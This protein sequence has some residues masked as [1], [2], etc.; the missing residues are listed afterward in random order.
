MPCRVIAPFVYDQAIAYLM[1]RWK[2]DKQR[3]LASIAAKLSLF[4]AY[5]CEIDQLILPMPLHWRRQLERGF[6]QS[7]DLL[8]AMAKH[9][10]S[11]A[12]QR[13]QTRDVP[14]LTRCRATPK[15]SLAT[16]RERQRNLAGAFRV[17]GD[18][19]G[20]PVLVIDD[21]CTTGATAAAVTHA[22]QAAGA[23]PVTLWCV[24]R[25]PR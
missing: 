15:Q 11:L 22:L 23:G 9:H 25:T 12:K 4:S 13:L 16:R 17:R 3:R 5:S 18:L 19:A 7:E 21:V 20:R 14:S 24:A 10:P 2:F 8:D 6:N 1:R